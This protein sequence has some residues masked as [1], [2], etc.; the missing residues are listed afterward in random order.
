MDGELLTDS[1]ARAFDDLEAI[2]KGLSG[3]VVD[4]VV[5]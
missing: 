3:A 1:I 2:G 4:K 5:L